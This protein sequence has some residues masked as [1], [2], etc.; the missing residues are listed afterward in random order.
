[1]ELI[2]KARIVNMFHESVDKIICFVPFSLSTRWVVDMLLSTDCA[3][4]EMYMGMNS[5][6]K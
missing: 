5:G 4:K 3:I 1:M 2:S 6:G